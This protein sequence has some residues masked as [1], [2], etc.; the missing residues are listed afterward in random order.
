MYRLQSYTNPPLK[1]L[2]LIYIRAR[3]T[4]LA[5]STAEELLGIFM[6]AYDTDRS[7]PWP[8]PVPTLALRVRVQ[9]SATVTVPTYVRCRNI[10]TQREKAN[11]LTMKT[12]LRPP[13]SLVVVSGHGQ[14]CQAHDDIDVWP[15]WRVPGSAAAGTK[16]SCAGRSQCRWLEQASCLAIYI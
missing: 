9:A 1:V 5:T 16:P 2:G 11:L 15:L 4:N 14:L 3:C 12:G 13:C 6:L 8:W 7:W 10:T